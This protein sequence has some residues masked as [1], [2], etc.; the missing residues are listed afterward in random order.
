VPSKIDGVYVALSALA[1]VV[2]VL[3]APLFPISDSALFEYFGWA[4]LHGQRLY[5]DLVDVKLP[6]IFVV[7]ELWQAL[8]GANYALHTYAEAALNAASIALFALFLRRRQIPAW[9]LGTFLFAV[10]FSIPFPEF[11]YTQHYAIFFIVLALYLS[12]RGR[13]LFAGGALALA[14]T[15]WIPAALTCI[16]IL[17]EPSGRR[18]RILLLG[19]FLG[20]AGLYALAM[21]AAFGPQLF[22]DFARIWTVRVD[23]RPF[24]PIY[25]YGLILYSAPLR[26]IGVLM[27]LLLLTVRRPVNAASRFALVWSACA[28]AGTAIP[29]NFYEHYF[30]PLTP[31]LSMAIASFG[32]SRENLV[33]RPIVAIAVLV[34]CLMTIAKTADATRESWERSNEVVAIGGWI[35]SSVG[36]DAFIFTDEFLP[37]LDLVTLARMPGPSSLLVYTQER[38]AWAHWAQ[39]IVFGP[40]SVTIPRIVRQGEPFMPQHLRVQYVPVCLGRTGHFVVYTL[41]GSVNLFRCTGATL[42]VNALPA[43]PSARAFASLR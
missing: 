41:P 24:N 20:T 8:F 28:L 36:S 13:H 22:T 19:G 15:F 12:A 34:L 14:T 29:P 5:A 35:R 3:K 18:G 21:L 27:L 42:A 25:V 9:A 11:N 10:F 30:L 16:P 2:S 4:M 26:A 33:R 40:D 32:L 17:L 39:V 37:E 1:V 38:F 23:A 7:N 6:S 43:G 31:A